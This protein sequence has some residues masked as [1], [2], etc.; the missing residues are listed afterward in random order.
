MP[1][2]TGS[3]IKG[4]I[5]DSSKILLRGGIE[6][7]NLV[8]QCICRSGPGSSGVG[9]FR[10]TRTGSLASAAEAV[11]LVQDGEIWVTAF[12][13]STP[14]DDTR[15]SYQGFVG[16]KGKSL[17]LPVTEGE[18]GEIVLWKTPS[19]FRILYPGAVLGPNMLKDF[20]FRDEFF[21]EDADRTFLVEPV[22]NLRTVKWA[23]VD[24]VSPSFAFEPAM[25]KYVTERPL[26][27]NPRAA[28]IFP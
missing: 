27:F 6:E 22:E 5:I 13:V 4:K 1:L 20:Q 26:V 2:A 9:Y 14:P 3:Y 23:V 28:K 21:Y 8:I 18:D 25:A 12:G 10:S 19:D 15:P 24:Q 16:D 7:G 11:N 17:T